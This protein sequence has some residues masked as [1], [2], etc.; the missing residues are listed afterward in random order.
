M[1]GTC[2]SRRGKL[3]AQWSRQTLGATLAPE[4]GCKKDG[5]SEGDRGWKHE[6]LTLSDGLGFL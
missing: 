6:E 4:A 1:E 2:G 5:V 3:S